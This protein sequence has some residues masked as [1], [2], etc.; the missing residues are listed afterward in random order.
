M[1]ETKPTMKEHSTPL[2]VSEDAIDRQTKAEKRALELYPIYPEFDTDRLKDLREA[3]LLGRGEAI[4]E[5]VTVIKQ[6][7]K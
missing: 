2:D 1:K 4:K 6:L 3:Y 7:E 5:V